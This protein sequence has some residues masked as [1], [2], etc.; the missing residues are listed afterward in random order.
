VFKLL[1]GKNKVLFDEMMMAS[2]LSN[3]NSPIVAGRFVAS[4]EHTHSDF[5]TMSLC[6]YSIAEKL[7]IDPTFVLTHYIHVPYL[8]RAC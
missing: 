6:S 7:Q 2:A 1:H 8:R 4:T 5:E 3:T